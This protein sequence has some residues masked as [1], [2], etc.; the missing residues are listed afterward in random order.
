M[1]LLFK[2]KGD[3]LE[4]YHT[5]I[6][7]H[8]SP[9]KLLALG[10]GLLREQGR[11]YSLSSGEK[12]VVL[13][14]LRGSCDIFVQGRE[15]ETT[16]R[17]IG[18]RKDPFSGN[19]T[20]VYISKGAEYQI[21]PTSPEVDIVFH[22]APANETFSSRLLRPEDVTVTPT[23]RKNWFREVR[24]AIGPNVQAQ[25]L[26][27]GE[28]YS[29]SGNWSSYPPHKHDADRPPKES[30]YEETYLFLFKPSTGFAFIR[31]YSNDPTRPLDETYTVEDGDAIAV[32]Y[33]Y[34]PIVTA[35]GYDLVYLF[36]LAGEGREY[37]TWSE[38]PNH[39]WILDG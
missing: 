35:P 24:T 14:I 33:G 8:N 1:D 2:R 10:R 31:L 7:P 12:E 30:P 21:A 15:K 20:A 27:T 36:A 4:G 39:A 17:R 25:R 23:G 37:G 32:P 5:I 6:G 38:D 9:L 3:S 18:E 28:T 22:M 19:P 16:Y 13:N 11:S 29:R 34:H 26:I